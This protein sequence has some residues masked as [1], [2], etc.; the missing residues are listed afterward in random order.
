MISYCCEGSDGDTDED[1]EEQESG[2]KVKRFE[3]I[4]GPTGGE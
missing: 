4:P 3:T 2:Y 1:D